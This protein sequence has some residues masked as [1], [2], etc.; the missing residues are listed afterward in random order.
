[1]MANPHS[2]TT[3]TVLPP[4]SPAHSRRRQSGMPRRMQIRMACQRCRHKRAKCDGRA[5]CKR[6]EEA[7]EQ[8]LYDAT[9]RES[10]DDLRA[11]IDRLK[12]KNEEN[13]RTLQA[14]LSTHDVDVNDLVANNISPDA[15]VF[16]LRDESALDPTVCSRCQAQLLTTP[17][18]SPSGPAESEASTPSVLARSPRGPDDVDI[19]TRTGWT[20]AAVRKLLDDLHTWDYFP[21]CLLQRDLF[22]RDYHTGST[23]FC[24][25]AL[26]NALLALATRV[27]NEGSD[28][29]S[30]P[31]SSRSRAFADE[32]ESLVQH[33]D[34]PLTSLPQVQA[35]GILSLYRASRGDENGA[36]K[37]AEL[38]ATHAADLC[39]RTDETDNELRKARTKTYC[40]AVSLIRQIRPRVQ[41]MLHRRWKRCY[42]SSN[43]AADVLDSRTLQLLPVKLFQLT[44]WVYKLLSTAVSRDD[45]FD[46]RDLFAVYTKCL[47]WYEG[48]FSLRREGSDTP[49][50]LFVHMYYQYC[51][52]S[53]FRPFTHRFLS[54]S[55]IQPREI[56]LQAANSIIEL[57]KSYK[58]LFS[59]RRVCSFIP[60]FVYAVGIAGFPLPSPRA[61]RNS[62]SQHCSDRQPESDSTGH[63]ATP[64]SAVEEAML[65]TATEL[66][67]EMG[68]TRK[69]SRETSINKVLAL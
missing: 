50:V 32:A 44:E 58:N 17:A 18:R 65:A 22:L 35:F 57:A 69:P 13:D 6:C 10:K 61:G 36:Q 14:I 31:S 59:L 27:V 54:D 9:H 67:T 62:L 3:T 34:S 7:G 15:L 38:F 51:L 43:T 63:Q 30:R 1:M 42:S 28:L 68:W 12:Q 45:G 24:S 66:L 46:T 52:L 40:G 49:F 55:D 39:I 2:L 16:H 47:R 60:C 37:L 4:F 19:W 8:C 23:R 5:P 64:R 56:Y 11:E 25:S 33:G 48:I 20:V 53:L 29:D 41:A 26:V 21:Y